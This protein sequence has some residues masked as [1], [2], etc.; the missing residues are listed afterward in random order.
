MKKDNFEFNHIDTNLSESDTEAA[1]DFYKHY[2][3]NFGV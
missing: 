3:K 2:T 1:K